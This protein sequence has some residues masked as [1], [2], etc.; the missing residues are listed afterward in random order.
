MLPIPDTTAA[1]NQKGRAEM[2]GSVKETRN[3][4]NWTP[5]LQQAKQARK[6]IKPLSKHLW[7][8]QASPEVAF[9]KVPTRNM[10]FLVR[11]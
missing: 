4:Q 7:A 1:G 8:A 10:K 6:G 9:S 11:L 2:K 5:R 3:F